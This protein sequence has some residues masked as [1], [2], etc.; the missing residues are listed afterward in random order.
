MWWWLAAAIGCEV[1]GTVSLRYSDGF[2][3]PGPVLVV[4]GAYA[5]SFF[6]LSQ[7]LTRGMHLASAYAIWSAIG[8]SAIAVLGIVLFDEPVT[9]V[10]LFGLVLVTAG[11]ITLQTGAHGGG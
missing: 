10:Q 3:R 4:L 7:A 6:A 2:T 8:I 11:V 5:L 1:L 9:R